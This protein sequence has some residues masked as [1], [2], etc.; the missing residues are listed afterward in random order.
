MAGIFAAIT[1]LCEQEGWELTELEDGVAALIETGG[2][3][4]EQF[5]CFA[6][7]REKQNQ[8]IFHSVDVEEVE[9]AMRPAVAEFI[10]RLNYGLS[11]G[12]FEMN[13][14]AGDVRFKTS[15]DFD[16][17]DA[18]VDDIATLAIANMTIMSKFHDL[19]NDVMAGKISPVDAMEI[20]GAM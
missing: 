17:R 15:M 1:E 2:D 18:G 19:L 4:D 20:V 16:K 9:P 10:T 5:T 8:F 3:E 13:F 12:N 11:I 7:A 6:Y 14:D